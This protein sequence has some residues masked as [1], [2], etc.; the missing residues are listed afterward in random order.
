MKSF[1]MGV[2]NRLELFG[3]VHITLSVIFLL[4][5]VSLYFFA[6]RIKK[7][8]HF[9]IIRRVCAAVLAVNMLLHYTARLVLGIWR[10]EDD[11]PLHI[12]FVVN[13][14]MI[15][16]LLSDNFGELYRVMYFFTFIGPM[17]AI[18]WP[19][20]NYSMDSFI[21]WQFVIS[22]HFM[23][24][25]SLYCLFVLEY[26]TKMKYII[27]AFLIGNTYIGAVW[28]FNKTFGT[29]YI[30]MTELPGQLYEVYP[31]LDRLPPLIWLEL[32]G[33]VVLFTSY[34]PAALEK[35]HKRRKGSDV[36][37]F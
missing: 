21:F 14:F 2:P 12:C 36:R 20:L 11:L 25:C 34:I 28:V 15:Y 37:Y 30:M 26:K 4:L 31:F 29:N 13:F 17:P 24:L 18:I 9:L 22:H 27:H 33:I 7:F 5:A 23:L 3:G 1:F 35:R 32:V 6:D 8:G 16:I 19:D 10:F